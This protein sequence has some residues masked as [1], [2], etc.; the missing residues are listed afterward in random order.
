MVRTLFAM[1]SIGIPGTRVAPGG[2]MVPGAEWPGGAT[3][4]WVQM[5]IATFR[6]SRLSEE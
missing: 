4:R 2:L 1:Q 3:V 6:H 5:S